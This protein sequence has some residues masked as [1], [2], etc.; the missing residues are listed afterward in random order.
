M[1][2]KWE[3]YCQFGWYISGKNIAILGDYISSIPPLKGT[4]VKAIDVGASVTLAADGVGVSK[5]PDPNGRNLWLTN[6]GDPITT[7][8]T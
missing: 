6:G 3:N 1:V 2:Y 7:Y 5:S 8:D 4:R